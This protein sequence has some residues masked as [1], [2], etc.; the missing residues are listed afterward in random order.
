MENTEYVKYNIVVLETIDQATYAQRLETSKLEEQEKMVA[1]KA[2]EGEKAERGLELLNQLNAGALDNDIIIDSTGLKYVILKEGQGPIAKSGQMVE[3]SYYGFL[4]N[5]NS[6]DNS[7]K[8]GMSYP[9]QL[10]T[11]GVIRGWEI[12]L[13][14]LN[15]GTEALF[16]IPYELGYGEA[17]SPPLIPEKSELIFYIEVGEI[18]Y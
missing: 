9:V 2:S 5:G 6:F 16:I 13:S 4:R 17:G 1:I 14:K 11:N 8:R 10:G 7:Y 12:G 15:S 18:F 3:T